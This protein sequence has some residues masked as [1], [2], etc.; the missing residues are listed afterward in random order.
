MPVFQLTEDPY[1]FPNPDLAPDSGILAV[2]GD[3]S[4][5]RLVSAYNISFFPWY[6]PGEEIMWWT[7][8]PRLVLFPDE[9]KIAKSMRPY[10][11]QKKFEV[12]YDQN[13]LDVMLNCKT[14]KR[15]GKQGG[16]TWI[17]T[18]IIEAYTKLHELGFAHSVEVWQEGKLVGG[19]YGL[20]I[21][22]VFFGES[23]FANVSNASKFGFISLVRKIQ[24]MGFTLIDCQQDTPHLNSLGAKTID[25][26]DF[27]KILD[28][29]SFDKTVF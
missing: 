24:V 28:Q 6:N 1:L 18:D 5:E 2:G 7:P 16:G 8:N 9:L 26:K 21:G 29:N 22:K 11:N 20:A 23:M 19:L 17:S 12:T 15:G 25:R 4:P 27:L 14:N 10:F 13:F 3:L